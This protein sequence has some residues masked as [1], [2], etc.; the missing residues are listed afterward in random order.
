MF[1]R[2]KFGGR[3]KGLFSHVWSWIRL[4][5]LGEGGQIVRRARASVREVYERRP[6]LA[7]Q[8]RWLGRHWLWRQTKRASLLV[9][10][11]GL[12][13]ALFISIWSFFADKPWPGFFNWLTG[14][15]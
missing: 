11:A 1:A 6:D 12:V 4:R 14:H 13:F 10:I 5:V 3:R 8:R 7:F 2:K 9:V 15:R